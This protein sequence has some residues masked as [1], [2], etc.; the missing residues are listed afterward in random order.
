MLVLETAVRQRGKPRGY[1][2]HVDETRLIFDLTAERVLYRCDVHLRRSLWPVTT[3][4]PQWPPG[5]AA[6]L[7]GV[8]TADL[9]FSE[10]TVN[11]KTFDDFPV[12][13]ST[14]K[15]RRS[16]LILLTL[17]TGPPLGVHL[18]DQV[19]AYVEDDR[20]IGFSI[21]ELANNDSWTP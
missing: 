19:L 2:I 1:S 16:A 3:P 10:E 8:A 20:L 9:I 18:S 13:L 14:D 5:M 17:P 6:G 12:R 21:D 15:F 11:Q 7:A 4:F